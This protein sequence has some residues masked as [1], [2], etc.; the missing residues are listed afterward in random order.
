MNSERMKLA[1]LVSGGGSN[2]QAIVDAVESGTLDIDINLVLSNKSDAFALERARN[3]GIPAVVHSSGDFPSKEEFRARFLEILLEH[4][5]NFVVL[6]GYLKKLPITV[7]RRFPR[8]IINIHPALLPKYGG[9]GFYGIKVHQA[10]IQAGDRET[11]VT[12]HYVDD[13]YDHGD[14]ILQEKVRVEQ[15]DTPEALAARVLRLEHSVLPKVLGL[16]AAGEL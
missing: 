3:H 5:V 16:L 2:L 10:V 13:K 15:D 6:A 9:M 12:I 8:R 11:G 4:E 1:V 14:I 7:I